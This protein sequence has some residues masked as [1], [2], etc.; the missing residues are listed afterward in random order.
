MSKLTSEQRADSASSTRRDKLP[1]KA[2]AVP[3]RRAYPIQD[4]S[5]ARNALARVVQHGDSAL[6]AKVRNA[7]AN[8]YPGLKDGKSKDK[9]P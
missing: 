6:R 3:L 8:R 7:V 9:A 4:L 5:H 1:N 2:F